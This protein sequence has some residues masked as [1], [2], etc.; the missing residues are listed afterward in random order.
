MDQSVWSEPVAC[1]EN[2]CAV[3]PQTTITIAKAAMIARAR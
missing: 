2:P 1:V 3:K